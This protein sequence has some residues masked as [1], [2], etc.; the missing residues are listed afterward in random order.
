MARFA[1]GWATPGGGLDAGEHWVD[2]AIREA[3]EEIGASIQSL[4]PFGI[5]ECS[6]MRAEPFAPHLPHP[7][8][9]QVVAWGEAIRDGEPTNPEGED[10]ALEVVAMTPGQ[11]ASVIESDGYPEFAELVFEAAW[12]RAAGVPYEIRLRDNA[13]LLERTLRG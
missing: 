1:G 5:F 13:R 7:R 9:D 6:S 4:H 3:R 10:Q 11:A 8:Y 12:R 2:A